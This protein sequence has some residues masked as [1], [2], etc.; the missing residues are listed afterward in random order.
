MKADDGAIIMM[1]ASIESNMG[2]IFACLHSVKPILADFFPRVFGT[3]QASSYRATFS[4]RSKK[5]LQAVVS[6]KDSQFQAIPAD[7]TTA[8]HTPSLATSKENVSD[9]FSSSTTVRDGPAIELSTRAVQ[10]TR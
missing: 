4:E 1:T 2:I 6:N 9:P 7:S 8:S 10:Y 5:Y 3:S